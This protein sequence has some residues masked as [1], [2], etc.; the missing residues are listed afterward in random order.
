MFHMERS[1]RNTVIIIACARVRDRYAHTAV[2]AAT[3]RYRLQ[4]K[5]AISPSGN[6]LAPGQ[7][8]LAL[9]Q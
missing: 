9:T 3:L 2:G 7:S 5:L 8:V 6:I 1:A 4:T